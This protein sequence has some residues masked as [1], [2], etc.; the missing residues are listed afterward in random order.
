[1]NLL[2]SSKNVE[3][4]LFHYPFHFV[5]NVGASE[6]AGYSANNCA[7]NMRLNQVWYVP[8]NLTPVL[9]LLLLHWSDALRKWSSSYS[10]N[11]FVECGFLKL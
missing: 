2:P 11:I 5:D 9:G 6:G 1:M 4:A 7:A 8:D 3:K 10:G